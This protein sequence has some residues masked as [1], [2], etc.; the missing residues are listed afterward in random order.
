MRRALQLWAVVAVAACARTGSSPDG[1]L[2][3]WQIVETTIT[4]A[5]STRV[6]SDPEP[7]LYVFTA[8]HFSNMLIQGGPREPFPPDPTPEQRLAAYDPFIADAGSYVRT[9]STLVTSNRIAKVPNVMNSGVTYRYVLSG[10]T[11]LLTFS[12]GWA[13]PDGEITYRL[14]RLQEPH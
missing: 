7:G 9:D 12:G 6:D 4:T 13:P 2:G 3:A 11:L 8:G 14:T 10:D 1:L 5:D